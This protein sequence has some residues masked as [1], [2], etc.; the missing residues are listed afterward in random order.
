MHICL[1]EGCSD[2]P[3]SKAL[4]LAPLPCRLPVTEIRQQLIAALA[5]HDVAVVSGETGS[6]KTT[7]VPQYI[8]EAAIEAG[9]G[10]ACSIVCTQPR[11]IA[12]ISV[13]ERVAAERGDP[14]PGQA[15]G[16]V[17]PGLRCAVLC[18]PTCC[19]VLCS[20]G[21]MSHRWATCCTIRPGRSMLVASGAPCHSSA[22]THTGGIPRA[23]GCG[24]HPRHPPP[25]LHH[26]HPAAAPCGGPSPAG[27]QPRAGGRGAR[28]HAAG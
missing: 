4:P 13:A 16:K 8:L 11:R 23:P 15:G 26:W 24:Y 18:V 2:E 21:L 7:Q 22:T 19:A 27:S 3:S 1:A 25:L 14:A 12:A 5:Q 10:G 6:G 9:G 20:G 28:A 17:S